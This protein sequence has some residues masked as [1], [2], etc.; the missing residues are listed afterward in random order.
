MVQQTQFNG[1]ATADPHLHLQTFLE[2][3]D[4]VKMNGVPEDIIRLRLFTFSLRDQ[5][6][7]WLQS[8]P[9]GSINTWEEMAV[10][11]LAKYFPPAKSTQ[12]KI[13]ISTFRHMDFEQLYE[14]WERR[15]SQIQQESSKR[16]ARTESRLDSLETHVVNMGAVLKS[17]EN[18][19]GHL[20]NALKDNNRGQF[21]SNTEVN[22]IEHCKTIDLRSVK[23]VEVQELAAEVEKKKVVD[24]NTVEKK[25]ELEKKPMYK[26]PL[27][28]PQR[29]KKKVLDEQFST[30]LEIFKKLHVNI[31]FADT[32][33]QMPNYAKFL[34]EVMSKKQK[35]ED[36]EMVN[37]IE[38]CSAILQKNLPQKLK[39]PGNFTIPC[40]IGSS[41]F[42]KALCHLRASIT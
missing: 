7:I 18:K 25:S 3:T 15:V 8:L 36:F 28:Y 13:E 34:K 1:S 40:I 9:M 21:P 10:K 42:N 29:F 6:R 35:L 39:D 33:L 22:L 23:E 27:P 20:E 24:E 41:N 11:F 17:M 30:F 14:A 31:P 16:R 19:I 38:E 2:I 37:L 26:P 12:L 5:A 32:L 4:T